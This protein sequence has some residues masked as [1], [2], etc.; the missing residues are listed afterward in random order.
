MSSDVPIDHEIA[1]I[2]RRIRSWREHEGLTLQDLA[3]RSGLATSTVQKVETGTMTP[4]VAVLLKLARGLGRRAAE[5]IHDGSYEVEVLHLP[6]SERQR[7]GVEGRSCFERLSGDLYDAALESW[8]VTLE[9]GA[10]SGREPI[11]YEGEELVVCERGVLTLQVA[12]RDHIL[13]PGDVLHFKA[14]LLHSWRND[15]AD[16]V[17]F[18][19]TGTLP[20]SFR[21]LLQ[22]RV[23]AGEPEST[24]SR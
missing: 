1:R 7:V 2:G 9:P 17:C 18:T 20:H 12:D 4:S 3:R 23:I 15:G 6:A 16:P 10:S 19:V 21:A 22:D 24:R 8:R 14:T 5:L 13:G 11:C